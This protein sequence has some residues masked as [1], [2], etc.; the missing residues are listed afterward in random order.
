MPGFGF[1]LTAGEINTNN[2]LTSITEDI[3]LFSVNRLASSTPLL[4]IFAFY[5][6]QTH[7]EGNGREKRAFARFTEP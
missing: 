2:C 1:T 3:V 6:L 4:L 5:L 7:M